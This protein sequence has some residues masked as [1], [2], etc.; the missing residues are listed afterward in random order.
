MTAAASASAGTGVVLKVLARS[1]WHSLKKLVSLGS[2]GFT[3]HANDLARVN[4]M[5][6]ESNEG[7]PQTAVVKHPAANPSPAGA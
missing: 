7:T 1:H 2:A 4:I 6:S 5:T 3:P